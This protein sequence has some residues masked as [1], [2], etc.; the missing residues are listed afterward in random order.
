MSGP[1]GSGAGA[2]DGRHH[3]PRRARPFAIARTAPP[4]RR[5]TIVQRR[6]GVQGRPRAQSGSHLF[7]F[8]R[9]T[10]PSAL[11]TA[12]RR[13][14]CG[15]ARFLGAVARHTEAPRLV[16]ADGAS[17]LQRLHALQPLSLC[18]RRGGPHRRDT[19]YGRP[20]PPGPSPRPSSGMGSPALDAAC[21]PPPSSSADAPATVVTASP[22]SRRTR[23]VCSRHRRLRRHG[24][25]DYSLARQLGLGSRASLSTR[26]TG[27]TI[28]V[29][30]P[31]AS[32]SPSS[33]S[34]WRCASRSCSRIAR[35]SWWS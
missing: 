11:S 5:V 14:R 21:Q 1:A 3:H 31:T 23:P 15:H 18:H 2:G 4:G 6:S 26:D 10:M 9:S 17:A 30:S 22:P 34:T 13:D 24:E 20:R 29:R 33:S 7:D 8:A 16:Q 35:A 32:M 27:A 12:P 19:G 28:P 25:G